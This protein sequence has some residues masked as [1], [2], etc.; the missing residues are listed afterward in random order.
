MQ[1]D[2]LSTVLTS[3][4][5]FMTQELNKRAQQPFDLKPVL[6][7]MCAN[8]FTHYMC[9]SRYAY[10]D[11]SFQK[12][13]RLFDL[14]FWDINQGYAVDFLPWLLPAYRKHMQQL[15]KWGTDIREFILQ[16]IIDE[17]RST[18]DKNSPRDFTDAL[19]L[20][21]ETESEAS[22]AALNWNHVLYELEDFLGGHSAVGN[23]LMRAIGAMCL[24]PDVMK[25]IQEEIQRT[26]GGQRPVVLEDRPLMPYTEAAILET[27]RL[28]SSPIVPHVAMQETSV[29]GKRK[30]L[31][32][33]YNW[34]LTS[35]FSFQ[36]TRSKKAPSSF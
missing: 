10:D 11:K 14:I 4:S 33:V 20:H 24:N 2:T 27:L 30:P 5:E 25:N 36:V 28:S 8:V 22:K 3:E 16:N 15:S 32:P 18:L 13:V 1:F 6:L 35:A 26:T 7:H 9:S 29:A 17:H 21:L 34:Q 31:C 19:L 12:V 23:L